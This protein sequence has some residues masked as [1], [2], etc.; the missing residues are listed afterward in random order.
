MFESK[1]VLADRRPGG[2]TK[3]VGSSERAKAVLDWKPRFED[4]DTI[5]SHAW[6][7]HENAEY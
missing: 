6:K 4:I 7:W 3:L 1:V 5:V 2:S